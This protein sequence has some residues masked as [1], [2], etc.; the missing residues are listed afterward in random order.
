MMSVMN[1]ENRGE[2]LQLHN[3]YNSDTS[4]YEILLDSYVGRQVAPWF[5]DVTY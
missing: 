3:T 2:I 1:L 5:R 4:V